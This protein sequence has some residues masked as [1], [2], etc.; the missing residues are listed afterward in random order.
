MH[1]TQVQQNFIFSKMSIYRQGLVSGARQNTEYDTCYRHH[2]LVI[3][4]HGTQQLC[5]AALV[6]TVARNS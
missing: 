3:F 2:P 6:G 1:H 5:V 4:T